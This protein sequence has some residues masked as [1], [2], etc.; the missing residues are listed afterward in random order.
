MCPHHL[1]LDDDSEDLRVHYRGRTPDDALPRRPHGTW[2]PGWGIAA[3]VGVAFGL[4]L[5]TDYS[6]LASAPSFDEDSPEAVIS[7]PPEELLTPP[8]IGSYPAAPP[9]ALPGSLQIGE[10][11]G[12]DATSRI[13]HVRQLLL[14]GH[15]EAAQGQWAALRRDE[16]ELELPPD[17]QHLGT[18]PGPR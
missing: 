1:P 4:L 6:E 16:P 8:E 11:A 2:H 10:P 17:L 7:P 13:E 5:L 18:T 12:P 3:T 14:D 15:Q 9:P